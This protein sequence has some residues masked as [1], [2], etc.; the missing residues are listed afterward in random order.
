LQR[1]QQLDPVAAREHEQQRADRH[2]EFVTATSGSA[3]APARI[4][5]AII[6][7]AGQSDPTGKVFFTSQQRARVEDH[8]IAVVDRQLHGRQTRRL[9]LEVDWFGPRGRQHSDRTTLPLDAVQPRRQPDRH[10][11]HRGRRG[12]RLHRRDHETGASW[13]DINVI[14]RC[15]AFTG[16]IS[17]VIWQDNQTIWITSTDLAPGGKRV[18]KA[19]IANPGDPWTRRPTR[20]CRSDCRTCR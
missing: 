17:N 2:P 16:F 13:T 18:I 5:T 10:Q 7:G 19:S 9:R 14:A 6:G 15:P 8:D 12:Q 4:S 20:S 3:T 1:G 11:P